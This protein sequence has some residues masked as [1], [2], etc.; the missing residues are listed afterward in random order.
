MWEADAVILDISSGLPPGT[1]SKLDSTLRTRNQL[2]IALSTEA[3]R[4]A[5]A[6]RLYPESAPTTDVAAAGTSERLFLG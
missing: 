4:M 6:V 2:W 5:G 3:L 1:Q